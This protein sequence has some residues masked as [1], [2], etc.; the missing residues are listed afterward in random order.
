MDSTSM[1]CKKI[2][3]VY[4]DNYRTAIIRVCGRNWKLL[5]VEEGVAC[6]T[7]TMQRDLCLFGGHQNEHCNSIQLISV[8]FNVVSWIKYFQLSVF[9]AFWSFAAAECR[10]IRLNVDHKALLWS[11]NPFTVD[12]VERTLCNFFVYPSL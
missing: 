11:V 10:F 3:A 5:N 7:D 4:F 8:Q 6:N 9:S 12:F 1:L 2:T